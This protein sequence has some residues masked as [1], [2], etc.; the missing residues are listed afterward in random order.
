MEQYYNNIMDKINNFDYNSIN[1]NDFS[2]KKM[3]NKAKSFVSNKLIIF[4]I[5]GVVISFIFF[6]FIS[7][8]FKTPF[9]I[10]VGLIIG[11]TLYK[12]Q[13]KYEKFVNKK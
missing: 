10:I 4:L 7:I 9:T 13:S 3:G 6:N 1:I 2:F 12:M 8:L 11:Y 5:V